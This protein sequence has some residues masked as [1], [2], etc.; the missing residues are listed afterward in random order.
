MS[1]KSKI[2][3][4]SK[5][6]SELDAGSIRHV[7]YRFCR[8]LFCGCALRFRER[9]QKENGILSRCP[10]VASFPHFWRNY[11]A[12][13]KTQFLWEEEQQPKRVSP[14]DLGRANLAEPAAT[15]C[16]LV[17]FSQEKVTAPRHERNNHSEYPKFFIITSLSRQFSFTFTHV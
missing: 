14:T 7:I 4:R 11:R 8:W 16:A 13:A 1:R 2:H 15:R 12:P 5:R 10:F 17:T 9:I 6:L 3:H